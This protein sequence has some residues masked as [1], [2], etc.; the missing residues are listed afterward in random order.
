MFL[1]VCVCP[2]GGIPTCLAGGIPTCL[3]AGLGGGIPACL[4]GGIPA[5]P[6]AG[7]WGVVSQHALQVVSQHALQQ[8]S[9]G[10]ACSREGACLLLGGCLLLGVPAP[11]RGACSWGVEETPWPADGYCC[12]RYASYWN[13]FLLVNSDTINDLEAFILQILKMLRIK[14]NKCENLVI[15]D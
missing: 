11:W 8:V 7:L 3:S 6:A 13:A 10:G 14:L 1:Q 12:G 4:A 2:Q 9:R 15:S 5:C